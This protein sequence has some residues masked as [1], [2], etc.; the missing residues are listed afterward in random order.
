MENLEMPTQNDKAVI[1]ISEPWNFYEDNN[2]I[3]KY[4]CNNRDINSKCMLLDV[5]VPLAVRNNGELHFF[6]TLVAT[7][8]YKVANFFEEVK[9]GCICNFSP[10]NQT[11][12]TCQE[13]EQQIIK[14]R[15]NT[16]IGTLQA[17]PCLGQSNDV[18]VQRMAAESKPED[19]TG[20]PD[21]PNS[22]SD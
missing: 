6:K 21:M 1:E 20:E 22:Q 14:Y 13:A 19:E 3:T 7:P 4:Y 8:R 17:C 10:L 18:P 11:V 16:L 12:S 2:C 5:C 9:K 15:G